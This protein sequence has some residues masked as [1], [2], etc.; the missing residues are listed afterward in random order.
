MAAF[1]QTGVL[2][3]EDKGVFLLRN[4]RI[5]GN[6]AY[7]GEVTSNTKNELYD[8]L[9]K[10]GEIKLIGGNIVVEGLI[11]KKAGLMNFR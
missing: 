9:M 8:R 4:M 5:E 6:N 11:I 2:Y 10:S 3:T 1:L 7:Y